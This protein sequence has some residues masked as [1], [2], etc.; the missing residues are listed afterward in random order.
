MQNKNTEA[1]L[2]RRFYLTELFANLVGAPL[3][4]IYGGSLIN[5]AEVPAG[6][7]MIGLA[8]VILLNQLLLALPMNLYLGSLIRKHQK[9]GPDY[10]PVR[11]YNFMAR[12]PMIQ[13]AL[14][15]GRMLLCIIV[16]VVN[17]G[18]WFGSSLHVS[19]TIIYGLYAAFITGLVIYYFLHTATTDITER[20]VAENRS[21]AGQAIPISYSGSQKRLRT[22]VAVLPLMMP[23]LLTSTGIVLLI[24]AIQQS[25]ADS[26]FFTARIIFALGLNLLTVPAILMYNRHFSKRRLIAI[27]Q[28][29]LD[30]VEHGNTGSLIA[31]DLRD[32]NS[33]TA[34]LMNDALDIFRLMLDKLKNT[35]DSLSTTV[36]HFSSQNRETV[37][38]TTQQASAVKEIVSTMQDSSSI[39]RQIQDQAIALAGNADESQDLVDS[40]FGKVQDTIQKMAEIREANQTT[41]QEI[42][43]LTE[44]ISSIGEIIELINGIANQT[45]I[46]AFNAELE[47]SSAG[48][49]GASFRI[50][51]EEIRRLAN[52]TVESLS[53]IKSRI[54]Q[55]QHY[56]QR[57]QTSS[58][59]GTLKIGEGMNLSRDLNTIF[60]QIRGSAE[61]TANN[62][63]DISSI[64]VGQNQAYEQIFATLKQI[65]EG[66]EQ[67]L[68]GTKDGSTET[69]KVQQLIDE[70]KILLQRFSESTVHGSTGEAS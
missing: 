11:V 43:E 32:D 40:G 5:F 13:S 17:V 64:L 4:T 59:E 63:K 33:R 31:S 70:L 3:A 48:A 18:A 49:A 12:L 1:A 50:V 22:F 38:A 61:H 9:G 67:I 23:S 47:A 44:E 27:Q 58:E 37:A 25:P 56:S 8:L 20:I 2:I 35:T 30:M 66:A 62:S 6:R 53:G 21:K 54:T 41:L 65:S 29:L 45:R 14:I 42:S 39:S 68:S 24:L 57:L 28:A 26:A 19:A 10:P 60:M 46:I 16:A 7:F 55:I 34:A 69:A 15:F 36:M 51:A 52:G